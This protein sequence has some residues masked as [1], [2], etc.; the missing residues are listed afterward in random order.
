[1]IIDLFTPS[2]P[3][4]IRPHLQMTPWGVTLLS[5]DGSEKGVK[6]FEMKQILKSKVT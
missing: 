4:Y 3:P 1:M 6:E 5:M 2:G